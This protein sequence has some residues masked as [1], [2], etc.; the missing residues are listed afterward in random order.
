MN[1]VEILMEYFNFKE[2]VKKDLAT[3]NGKAKERFKCS[4]CNLQKYRTF[5]NKKNSNYILCLKCLQTLAKIEKEEKTKNSRLVKVAT[6]NRVNALLNAIAEGAPNQLL[7]G[8]T[9]AV[10]D[11]LL[12]IKE[13]KAKI[14]PYMLKRSKEDTGA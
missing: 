7:G 6:V 13:V 14:M 3:L 8:I 11:A 12:D 1:T 4:L 2:W 5:T 9:I 10:L